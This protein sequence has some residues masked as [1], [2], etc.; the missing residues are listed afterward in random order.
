MV[1][2]AA[3]FSIRHLPLQDHGQLLRCHAGS[4]QGALPLQVGRSRHGDRDIAGRVEAGEY[5][6]A[7]A[8]CTFLIVFMLLI[9]FLIQR[10]VGERRLGRRSEASVST[11][12]FLG[13]H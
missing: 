4:C 9:I 10:G 8:Y 7:I 2:A 12:S 5:A 3:L 6:L 11:D 13:A 1:G